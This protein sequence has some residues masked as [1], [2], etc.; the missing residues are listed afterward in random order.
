[1]AQTIEETKKPEE[2]AACGEEKTHCKKLAEK[3]ESSTL[4]PKISQSDLHSSSKTW[5]DALFRQCRAFPRMDVWR[6]P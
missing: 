5:D 4:H 6:N 2:M 1:M 3:G